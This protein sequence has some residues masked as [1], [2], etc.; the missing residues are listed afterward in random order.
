MINLTGFKVKEH[1]A[2]VPPRGR[3]GL[4]SP[5]LV[6]FFVSFSVAHVSLAHM[7]G[8]FC[9]LSEKDVTPIACQEPEAC[10]AAA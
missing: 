5:H 9:L 4:F 3:G 6:C 7:L 8:R 1:S 10:V 2:Q